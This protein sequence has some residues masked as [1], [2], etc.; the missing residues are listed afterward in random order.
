MAH[1]PINSDSASF[2]SDD[3][4]LAQVEHEQ[5]FQGL[6]AEEAAK[7]L[8]ARGYDDAVI[9]EVTG[10]DSETL[11]AASM[12]F[13]R[14]EQRDG[15]GASVWGPERATYSDG[16]HGTPERRPLS[17]SDTARRRGHNYA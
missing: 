9:R 11:F 2:R 14:I 17:A 4:R 8:S 6:T 3:L 1:G 12:D 5:Y 16:E 10:V 13:C 7:E 15:S